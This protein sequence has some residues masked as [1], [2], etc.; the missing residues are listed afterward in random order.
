MATSSDFKASLAQTTCPDDPTTRAKSS[1]EDNFDVAPVRTFDR[2]NDLP[3]EL[4][5][6]I[7]ENYCRFRCTRGLVRI[8]HRYYSALFTE[9]LQVSKEMRDLVWL[10]HYKKGVILSCYRLNGRHVLYAPR[11]TAARYIRHIELRINVREIQ[12][13]KVGDTSEFDNSEIRFLL[14][15]LKRSSSSTKWQNRFRSLRTL[16][17]VI[18]AQSD[19]WLAQAP[20]LQIDNSYLGEDNKWSMWKYLFKGTTIPIR[21]AE[22]AAQVQGF[23]CG[24]YAVNGTKTCVHRCAESVAKAIEERITLKCEGGS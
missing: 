5:L 1:D 6:D 11:A 23:R 21:P 10:L 16:K 19:D 12:K 24:G 13:T 2:F 18:T 17:I 9:L 8:T 3:T 7:I 4:K 22:L 14:K 15:Q 20:C